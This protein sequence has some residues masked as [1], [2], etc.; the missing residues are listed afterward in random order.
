MG[1]T[2]RH[3]V[4]RMYC[5]LPFRLCL[6]STCALTSVAQLY[7]LAVSQPLFQYQPNSKVGLTEVENMF[8]QMQLVTGLDFEP[9]QLSA[10][11]LAGEFFGLNCAHSSVYCSK[12]TC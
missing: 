1:H 4:V 11:P 10:S 12:R 9:A 5:E 2:R 6:W 8:Y 3:L 7:E